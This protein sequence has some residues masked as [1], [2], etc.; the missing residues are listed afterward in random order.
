MPTSLR[1]LLALSVAALVL[2]G[3]G[4]SSSPS[5]SSAS[6]VASSPATSGSTPAASTSAGTAGPSS[7][8]AS[9]AADPSGQLKFTKSA[10]AAKA[11]QVTI[12][13]TNSAPVD[14]NF[15][16]AD[17]SGKVLGATP[18][19]AGGSHTLSLKLAPGTYTFYCSV[20][21]HRMAGMQG[22]LTVS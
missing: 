10:L 21:G 13:F 11:G 15:T 1:T 20:P 9:I 2:A 22:T 8:R 7:S 14:H 16:L 18:T 4:S 6:S 3:C 19:F 5:T 17:S 12:A